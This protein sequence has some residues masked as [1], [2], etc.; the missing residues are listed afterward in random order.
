MAT[1][2]EWTEET[3]NPITG[4]TRQS[5]GCQHCYAEIMAR[6]LQAMKTKG[7][8]NGFKLTLHPE[9]LKEPLS[10]RI[11]TSYFVNSMSDLF[12]E[13]VSFD[14]IDKIFDVICQTPKHHYQILTKRAEIMHNYFNLRKVPDNVWVGV[15]VEDKKNGV[16]RMDCLREIDANIRF[17]SAEPLL[18][19]LGEL[20]LNGI[21]WVIVGGESGVSAR[22][23]DASWALNIKDQCEQKGV[24]FFFK[25]WGTWGADKKRGSKK[26]NGRILQ[27]REWNEMPSAHTERTFV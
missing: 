10:R 11:P 9:R 20:N 13:D 26:E 14:F 17:I 21:H 7:Y 23:M 25:Q 5:A 15:T 27:G 4:C 8:E 19:D 16:P 24:N 1:K 2:I 18:E 12:H 22:P 6:R 3:W